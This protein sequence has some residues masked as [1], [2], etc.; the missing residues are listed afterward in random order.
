MKFQSHNKCCVI[1]MFDLY[2]NRTVHKSNQPI[3]E[4]CNRTLYV[5]LC[6]TNKLFFKHK[7]V[8]NNNYEIILN[9]KQ[10]K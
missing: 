7:S 2:T 8:F 6:I 5:V 9:I 1:A 10:C 3:R 4:N